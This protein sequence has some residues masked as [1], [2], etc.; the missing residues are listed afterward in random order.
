MLMI[1]FHVLIR[2]LDVFSEISSNHAASTFTPRVQT[3]LSFILYPLS[4]ELLLPLATHQ[5]S[6]PCVGPAGPL[7]RPTDLSHL[8]LD[9]NKVHH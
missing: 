4:T 3:G 8:T 7:F 6:R 1:T 5:V 2:H 9:Y